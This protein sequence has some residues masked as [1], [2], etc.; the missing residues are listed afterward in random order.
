MHIG[1]GD[2]KKDNP[3]LKELPEQLETQNVPTDDVENTNGTNQG[4]DLLFTYKPMAVPEE[5]KGCRTFSR[6]AK[7]DE[8]I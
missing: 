4:G 1:M 6:R 7:R 3:D 2:K 5:Q 8:K